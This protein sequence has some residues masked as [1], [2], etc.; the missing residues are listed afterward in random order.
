MRAD[1]PFPSRAG[2][3]R[4]QVIRCFTG[5]RVP[6]R[7]DASDVVPAVVRDAFRAAVPATTARPAEPVGS[8]PADMRKVRDA[9]LP[10]APRLTGCAADHS[11]PLWDLHI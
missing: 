7:R 11:D 3:V 6:L 2:T 1:A 5:R 9:R 8:W 10:D 4:Q